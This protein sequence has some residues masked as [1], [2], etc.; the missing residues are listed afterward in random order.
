MRISFALDRVEAAQ[1]LGSALRIQSRRGIL[2]MSAGARLLASS[3]VM[4]RIG[5]SM[6]WKKRL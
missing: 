2:M 4:V 1:V 6:C 5:E 3:A